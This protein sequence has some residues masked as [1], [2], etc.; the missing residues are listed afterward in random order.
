M[1]SGLKRRHGKALA[2]YNAMVREYAL[3]RAKNT[4]IGSVLG[5]MAGRILGFLVTDRSLPLWA[6]QL[7]T[8]GMVGA[9][10]VFAY[11]FYRSDMKWKE[12]T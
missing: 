3:T 5:F 10:T 2:E 8:L 1:E 9:A 12:P 6:D 4:W 7:I 11:F